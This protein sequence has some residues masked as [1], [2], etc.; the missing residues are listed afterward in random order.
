MIGLAD[1][2]ELIA[3]FLNNH[4]AALA[5]RAN[6]NAPSTITRCTWAGGVAELDQMYHIMHFGRGAIQRV[7]PAL[8]RM[9]G[10]S[11][12]PSPD[13]AGGGPTKAKY[14]CREPGDSA[15]N[16]VI[17]VIPLREWRDWPTRTA[18]DPFA[19]R[20][21]GGTALPPHEA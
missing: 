9:P 19:A 2:N 6:Q 8:R 5:Q 1:K 10:G 18:S 13:R 12:E 17:V 14:R 7:S 15:L 21:P 11:G 20:P 16:P 3:L 4:G